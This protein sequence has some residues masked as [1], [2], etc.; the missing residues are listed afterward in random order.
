M[1]Y[2]TTDLHIGHDRINGRVNRR[3]FSQEFAIAEC[4]FEGSDVGIEEILDSIF[5]LVLY[6]LLCEADFVLFPVDF[7]NHVDIDVFRV[8]NH[9]FDAG[10]VLLA[11]MFNDIGLL[12]GRKDVRVLR[13]DADEDFS[14]LRVRLIIFTTP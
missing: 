10:K 8:N 3:K 14:I 1:I 7:Q 11:Q 6:L 12:R 13:L 4:G 5:N 9:R 2:V